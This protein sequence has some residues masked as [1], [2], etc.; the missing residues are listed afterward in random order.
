M[1]FDP[2][3][4]SQ[5]SHNC[6]DACRGEPG[7]ETNMYI[8]SPSAFIAHS[9]SLSPVESSKLEGCEEEDVVER[10]I[11]NGK[12]MISTKKHV[13]KHAREVHVHV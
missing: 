7:D 6:Y 10:L 4:F 2:A 9:L 1:T 3:N 12:E 5:R 8:R 11:L 13:D